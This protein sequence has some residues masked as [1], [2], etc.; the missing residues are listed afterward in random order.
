MA[1][2]EQ[3]KFTCRRSRR[4][5]E[6]DLLY[7]DEG[8]G[9]LYCKAGYCPKGKGDTQEALT[10]LQIENRRL[11]EQVRS[12]GNDQDRL[13][14]KVESLQD[15]LATALEIRDIEQPAPLAA[16]ATGMRSETVP[17]LLCSDWHCGAVVDPATVCGLN[18]YDV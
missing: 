5:R 7:R 18:R 8:S 15:Q 17:L 10:Q 9:E 12:Q 4:C 14:S 13:L 1:A 3:L 16:G 11:R 2:D 6:N